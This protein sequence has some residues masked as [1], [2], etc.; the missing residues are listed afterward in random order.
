MFGRF[1]GNIFGPE[2]GGGLGGF[3]Q[4]YRCY[5]VTMLDNREDVERGGKI[6]M[7]PSALDQLTR[8]RIQYPMQFKL[9]NN[10]QARH[11]HCG[12]LEFVANEG[13]IYI[14][15]WMMRNLLLNEGDLVE[16]ENVSLKVATFTKF[17]PQSVDFLDIRYP[18][19][20][21]GNMLRSFA[22]LTKGDVI[23]IKY[24]E[25]EYKL[26]VLE[27][28]PD[29]AIS[30]TECDLDVDFAPP[31]GY[32]EPK[33]PE[34][35]EAEDV[36]MDILMVTKEKESKKR[37]EVDEVPAVGN[38]V[39][40]NLAKYAGDW[41]QLGKVLKVEEE[42]II[43]LHWYKGSKTGPWSPCIK[44]VPG[45]RGKR[46][47]WC[48]AV[49]LQDI[50]CHSFNLT[51]ANKLPL[52]IKKKMESFLNN[53]KRMKKNHATKEIETQ[54]TGQKVTRH[55][56]DFATP[57]KP[58]Y[59]RQ[60]CVDFAPPLGYQEPK[61]PEKKHDEDVEMDSPSDMSKYLHKALIIDFAPPVGYQEPNRPEKKHDEDLDMDSPLDMSEYLDKTF[62]AFSGSGNRLD[63]KKIGLNAASEVKKAVPHK[64]GIPNYKHKKGTI[65]FI[66]TRRNITDKNEEEEKK[67]EAFSGPGQMLGKKE[68]KRKVYF[69]LNGD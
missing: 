32:Q 42:E 48:E 63:G 57:P 62:T 35:K 47:A 60:Q 49:N 66:R 4:T 46:E 14:P 23:S 52:K 12:V 64:R 36:H 17:Q 22:C 24:N 11:T 69:H 7:P 65:T 51:P 1:G 18:E 25:R 43:Q 44:T 37:K 5:S 9:R 68:R 2:L 61:R 50:W 16:V 26:C 58:I 10:Q 40:T 29:D 3:K 39:L 13:R 27:T 31:V 30:V 6:I 55:K 19:A 41:P 15:N 28:K 34:K 45:T 33:R 59:A 20:V 67:F 38:Y 53:K 56:V 54:I 21:L 8:S